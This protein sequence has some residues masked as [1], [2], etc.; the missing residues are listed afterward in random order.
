MCSTTPTISLSRLLAYI[1]ILPPSSRRSNTFQLNSISRHSQPAS[2]GGVQAARRGLRAREAVP[3][4]LRLHPDPHHP[5]PPDHPDRLARPP[6]HEAEVLPPRRNPH[7][8]QPHRPGLPRRLRADHH[9]LQEPQRPH[10]HI[11]RPPRRLRGVQG[12]AGHR[13]LGAPQGLPGPRGHRRLVADPLRH[14]GPRRALP[15]RRAQPGPECRG[16]P[17]RLQGWGEAQV[18][19]RQLD[20]G[21]LPPLRQLSGLHDQRQGRRRRRLLQAAARDGHLQRRCLVY[22]DRL[23]RGEDK[24][25]RYNFDLYSHKNPSILL[26]ISTSL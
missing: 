8:V 1:N 26:I 16:A 20:V 14:R 2:H 23:L 21:T 7:P 10:R 15:L 22:L 19:G 18:E 12:A 13:P 24:V 25:R 4:H 9:L 17:R 6:P 11:L 3:A 5:H